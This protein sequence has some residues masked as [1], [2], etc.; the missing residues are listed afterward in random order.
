MC[1]SVSSVCGIFCSTLFNT[2]EKICGR[3]WGKPLIGMA[4]HWHRFLPCIL[5]FWGWICPAFPWRT[6]LEQTQTN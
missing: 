5:R 4:K 2:V 3:D 1:V 6:L